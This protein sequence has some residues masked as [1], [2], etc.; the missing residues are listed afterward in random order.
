MITQCRDKVKKKCSAIFKST[1]LT[2]L[3][4]QHSSAKTSPCSGPIGLE[5]DA[6]VSAGQQG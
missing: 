2:L 3:I 6:D 4:R 5:V 1:G